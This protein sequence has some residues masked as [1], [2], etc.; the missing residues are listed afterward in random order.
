MAKSNG[1][2]SG[3]NRSGGKGQ[4][5]GGWL[6]KPPENLLVVAKIMLHLKREN[7]YWG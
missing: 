5:H 6:S 4:G 1:N 3:G 2:C 7:N